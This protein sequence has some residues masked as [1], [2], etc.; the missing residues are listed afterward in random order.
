MLDNDK[1]IASGHNACAGCGQLS[2]VQSVMRALD[3]DTIIIN[4]TGCLEVTTT[5]YPQSVWRL[6]WMHSLFENSAAVAAG[7][8]A[9]LRKNK[10]KTK[11]IVQAGD[12]ATF[13]IGIG[14]IS[15][16]FERGD[17]VLYICYDT[18]GYSNTGFQ[19]SGSTPPGALTATTPAG[20]NEIKK[21]MMAIALAHQVPYVA[22]TAAGYPEDI[23]RK[24]KRALATPGPSYIQILSPCIPGWKIKTDEAVRAAKLAVQTGLYPLVEFQDGKLVSSSLSSKTMLLPLNDYISLQGRFPNKMDDKLKKIVEENIKRYKL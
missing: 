18:E 6:P 5:S 4:A 10:K 11:V 17:E 20:A 21:D 7:V 15:G 14:F 19:S 23:V 9:A 16:L 12:G 1:K 24:V 3:K 22:Q 8:R 2:A 13:D